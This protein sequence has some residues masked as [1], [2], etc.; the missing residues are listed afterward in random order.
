MIGVLAGTY[1]QFVGWCLEH[2]YNPRGQTA[3]FV[4]STQDLRARHFDSFKYVGTF[5]QRRDADEINI[6]VGYIERLQ[7]LRD[8]ER[9]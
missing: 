6:A 1:E 8:W 2:G 9:T 4:K 3:I 7:E 5:W